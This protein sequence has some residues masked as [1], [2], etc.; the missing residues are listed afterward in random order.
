MVSLDLS[1]FLSEYLHMTS[2]FFSRQSI[3]N[4]FFYETSMILFKIKQKK[5]LIKKFV[6]T[7]PWNQDLNGIRRE[8]IR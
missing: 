3:G 4:L 6:G 1:D 7:P 5:N 2:Q 8:S